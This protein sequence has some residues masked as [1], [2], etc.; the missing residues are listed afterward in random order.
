MAFNVEEFKA[1]GLVRG[2]ARPSLF[3]VVIP[4]WP[5]STVDS[6]QSLRFLCRTTSIPPSQVG[7]IDVPYFGRQIKLAG[8]RVYADWN[9]T[10]MHDE[11]YN[12]RKAV[13]SW[14]TNIN[15]HIENKMT[16]GVSPSPN[17]YK[18]D[19][20]IRHYSKDGSVIQTYTIKGMFPINISQMGLDFD[21]VNQVMTF[22]VDFAL[23]YWLPGDDIGLDES[24]FDLEGVRRPN[25]GTGF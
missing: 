4:E 21:A 22:D 2:G 19:A 13:E 8:D 5:G 6:E 14:H 17:S 15:Q 11:T 16:G 25:I 1:S 18:R 12:I 20:V 3:H 10:I 23:D 9:V 7:A 24:V